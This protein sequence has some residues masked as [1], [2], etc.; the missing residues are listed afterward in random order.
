MR[1]TDAIKR[2]GESIG[3]WCRRYLGISRRDERRSHFRFHQRL[4]QR[5]NPL[6]Q[7]FKKLVNKACG[8]RRWKSTS[9]VRVAEQH[10][11]TAE[12]H[13]ACRYSLEVASVSLQTDTKV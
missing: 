7:L 4:G 10:P 13:R 9:A 5:A 11:G 1:Y 8:A 12:C 2:E 3:R 6:A